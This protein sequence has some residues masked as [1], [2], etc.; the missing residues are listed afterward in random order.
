[1]SDSSSSLPKLVLIDAYSLLFRAF[2]G[3]QNFTTA[4]NRPTGALYGFTNMLFSILTSEKPE[5]IVVCWDAHS[6]TLRKQEF[7][8]YKAHRPDTDDRL[9]QQMPVA[10]ELVKAFGIQSAELDGYEADDLIGTLAER[11]GRDGYEVA[12]FTGDSDQLQLV[13]GNTTV[14]MTVRGVSDIKVYNAEAVYER[15]GVTPVQI[16]DYK[17]LT[18]DTSDNIPGV[19]GI[20]E[21]TAS[22]LLQKFGDLETLLQKK[23]EVTPPRIRGLLEQY[24]EQARISRRLAT[25]HRDAPID[26]KIVHYE[27]TSKNRTELKALFENLEF[28]SQLSR[29]SQLRNG[30]EDVEIDEKPLGK[31]DVS[32]H[33]VKTDAEL[34]E[35][36]EACEK[37]SLVSIQP[38]LEG[39]GHKAKI[40]GLALAI[41]GDA[42][43]YLSIIDDTPGKQSMLFG[44]ESHFEISVDPLRSFLASDIRF[45]T[46][47]AK[48]TISAL[49]NHNLRGISVYFD[50]MLAAYLIG[51]SQT[52]LAL[53]KL[54]DRYLSCS[55]EKS[56]DND[57][58]QQTMLEAAVIFSLEKVM[59]V[60][61]DE[62]SLLSVMEKVDLPLIP[63]LAVVEHEGLQLDIKYLNTL[64]ERLNKYIQQLTQEIYEIVGYEFNIS[65]TK[66]LQEVL[67]QKL[68]LPHGKKTKTG[69]STDNDVLETLVGHH[70]IAGKIIEYRE[71]SKLKVTYTDALARLVDPETNRVHTSLNQ[72]V[73]AT[74]RLSSSDPNLQNIPVRT[75]VGREIRRAFVAPKGR[76]LLSCDYSQVELRV[77]AHVSGDST[78]SE[79]FRNGEDIHTATASIVFDV[80]LDKV[81][82]DQRR[83]AKTINFAVL[84]GQSAFSLSSIL[85]VEVSVAKE[86]I[87]EYFDRL[88]GVKRYVD[89][90]KSTAKQCGYVQTMMGRRRYMPE[91]DSPNHVMR[92]AAERAAVNM[93]IQG[94]AAD[95]MKIAMINVYEWLQSDA[96]K[97][98]NML[99]QVHDELLFE[100]DEGTESQF[101]P[102]IVKLM[103]GAYPLNVPLEVDAKLGPNWAD[104]EH[105]SLA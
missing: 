16:A 71:Q 9:I 93:P 89:D 70:E 77:L 62:M 95:I 73:A 44:D 105:L 84:Y 87:N 91:L 11:G 18:G 13:G 53:A 72:T 79:A 35:A 94:A 8:A 63:V 42:A 45:V 82:R 36:I 102:E 22:S 50:T 15:Y 85:G 88:P 27:P 55:L 101:A 26:L 49:L 69:Y 54:C 19:P 76:M 74:G 1:M 60:K 68:Q 100:I 34:L 98:C 75:E 38:L 64:G 59:A 96:P 65:S 4:D 6:P 48:Q 24:D 47:N 99:L 90:T 30:T 17:A 58:S 92:A 39:T 103:E 21:K 20:G 56:S 40:K 80:D 5:A 25:I 32:F 104:M 41:S 12:I 2:F 7:D 97:G 43:W 81:T 83:Q 86:W 10:R 67:F 28:K 51:S 52:E 61:L 46:Y 31:L 66:Q 57:K 14:R 37:A 3:S 78:L 29:V 23:E 33:V